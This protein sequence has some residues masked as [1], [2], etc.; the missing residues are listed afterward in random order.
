MGSDDFCRILSKFE[1]SFN[2]INVLGKYHNGK[3][4]E[5][6]Y[7]AINVGGYLD[8]ID[9]RESDYNGKFLVLSR[10]SKNKSIPLIKEIKK[11]IINKDVAEE[12]HFFFLDNTTLFNPIISEELKKSLEISNL[13]L[14]YKKLY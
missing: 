5:K 12:T 6:K 1:P 3:P 8:A 13:H 7:K 14:E 9:Y 11:L 4:V 2:F 10:I